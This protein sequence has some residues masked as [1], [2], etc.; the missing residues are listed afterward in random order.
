MVWHIIRANILLIVNVILTDR[1]WVS[2]NTLTKKIEANFQITIFFCSG[3]INLLFDGLAYNTS[4]HFA[5]C[6]YFSSPLRGSD[7]YHA[8]RKISARMLNHRI[9]CI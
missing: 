3:I 2:L 7:K 9:R 5:H 8:T 4:G 6:S 1:I